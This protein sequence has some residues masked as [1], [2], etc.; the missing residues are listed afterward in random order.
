[1][2]GVTSA[3]LLNSPNRAK[4]RMSVTDLSISEQRQY[5]STTMDSKVNFP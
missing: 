5:T 4:L 1:M 3:Q 2:E